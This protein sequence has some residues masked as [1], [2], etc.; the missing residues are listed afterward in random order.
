MITQDDVTVYRYLQ[1]MNAN[2]GEEFLAW[3][4]GDGVLSRKNEIKLRKDKCSLNV[5]K[6]LSDCE[7]QKTVE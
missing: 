4:I 1:A 6:K 3:H 2:Q 7:M 5:R